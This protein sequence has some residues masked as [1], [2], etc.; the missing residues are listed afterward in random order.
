MSV[1]ASV[2]RRFLLT[3]T[4][5]PDLDRRLNVLYF[6]YKICYGVVR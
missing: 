5:V 6:S 2:D 3:L 4:L 1:V